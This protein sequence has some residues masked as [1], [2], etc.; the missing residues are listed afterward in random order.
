MSPQSIEDVIRQIVRDEL[1][2]A[3]QEAPK[4]PPVST[5]TGLPAVRLYSIPETAE[6]LGVSTDTVYRLVYDTESGQVD[7]LRAIDI[8]RD[9]RRRLRIRAD[10]YEDYVNSL[11]SRAAE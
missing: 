1:R 4:P 2:L 8:G 3:R 6:L 5:G 10:D 11:S 9:G 7:G